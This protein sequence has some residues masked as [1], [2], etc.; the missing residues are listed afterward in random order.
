MSD[1]QANIPVK[2]R[3]LPNNDFRFIGRLQ[4]QRQARGGQDNTENEKG[5]FYAKIIA[6]CLTLL[7]DGDGVTAHCR[8]CD[9]VG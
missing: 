4:L 8:F 3:R 9:G 1:G 6:K 7:C 2:V 5:M